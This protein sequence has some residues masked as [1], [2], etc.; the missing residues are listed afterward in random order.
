MPKGEQS[1][2]TRRCDERITHFFLSAAFQQNV[3][4]FATFISSFIPRALTARR[5]TLNRFCT[6]AK[7]HF[8]PS[9]RKHAATSEEKQLIFTNAKSEIFSFSPLSRLRRLPPSPAPAQPTS[10]YLHFYWSTRFHVA[11]HVLIDFHSFLFA[12]FSILLYIFR[13]SIIYNRTRNLI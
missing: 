4:E 9:T 11:H 6:F 12:Q 1:E 2:G 10:E 8:F 7:S 13:Y 3:N 5:D